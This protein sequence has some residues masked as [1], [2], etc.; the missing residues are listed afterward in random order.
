M[1]PGPGSRQPNERVTAWA[2]RGTY[3]H[4]TLLTHIFFSYLINLTGQYGGQNN[5]ECN[6]LYNFLPSLDEKDKILF[7]VW[8]VQIRFYFVLIVWRYLLF[9]YSVCRL[10]AAADLCPR[11]KLDYLLGRHPAPGP[12]ISQEQGSYNS[13]QQQQ[14]HPPPHFTFRSCRLINNNNITAGMAWNTLIKEDI[15]MQK[16]S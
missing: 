1:R 7:V 12:N 4:K 8:L 10:L 15:S 9:S 11:C 6:R 13:L 16:L 3:A 2:W 14:R 5:K